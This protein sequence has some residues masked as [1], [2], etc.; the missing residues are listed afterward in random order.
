MTIPLYYSDVPVAPAVKS[1]YEG[2]NAVGLSS[3][4]ATTAKSAFA[5]IDWRTVLPWNL[6]KG[7]WDKPLVNG[8]SSVNSAEQYLKLGNG[9][10]LYV[11][12][13]GILVGLT[14]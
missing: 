10:W 4:S 12:A 14:A 1:L 5:G 11:D 7:V 13:D 9:S 3:G 6:E 2:W 8:G